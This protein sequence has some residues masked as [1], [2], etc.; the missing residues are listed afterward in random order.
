METKKPEESMECALCGY[1]A[2]GR[3]EGDICPQ[4]HLT[5]WRCENCRYT[6]TAAQ[7][8]EVCPGCHQKSGFLNITCYTPECGGPGGIDPRL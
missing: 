2:K 7:P 6:L 1:N 8:P 3:F 4:C 5:Y